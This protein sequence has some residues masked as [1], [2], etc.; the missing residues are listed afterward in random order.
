M[1]CMIGVESPDPS[2]YLECIPVEYAA[3]IQRAQK[4]LEPITDREANL[5]KQAL[6]I[7]T[8]DQTI[9]ETLLD[10]PPN[11]E[12]QMAFLDAIGRD[13]AVIRLICYWLDGGLDLPSY[14]FREA[15]RGLHPNNRDAEMLLI[16]TQGFVVKPISA[17]LPK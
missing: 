9:R 16:G 12:E 10:W 8:S 2:D 7:Q 17:C 6:V 4:L 15:L 11:D 14:D 13:T 5:W 1:R 3:L